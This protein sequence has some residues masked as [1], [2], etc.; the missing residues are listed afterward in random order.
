MNSIPFTDTLWNF[1]HSNKRS[2]WL[3]IG[4]FNVYVRKSI[5][6]F[7]GKKCECLD[8]ASVESR[9][10]GSHT[11]DS[12]LDIFVRHAK[13]SGL[14]FV[15]IENV[16]NERLVKHI[17]NMGGWAKRISDNPIPCYTRRCYGH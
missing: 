8:L 13:D 11:F 16:C 4:V 15:Y 7:D 12:L 3:V 17:E 1:I 9:K 5:R 6:F 2:A 14:E 10:L